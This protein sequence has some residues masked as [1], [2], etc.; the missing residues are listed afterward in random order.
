MHSNEPTKGSH[1]EACSPFLHEN[2]RECPKSDN[3]MITRAKRDFPRKKE[4]RNLEY[5]YKSSFTY[6]VSNL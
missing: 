2:L 3:G 6:E 5:K 1:V 4:G